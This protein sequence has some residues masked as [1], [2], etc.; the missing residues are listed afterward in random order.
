MPEL[1]VDPPLG[2]N[3]DRYRWLRGAYYWCN[4]VV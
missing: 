4:M 3:A 2:L 1:R